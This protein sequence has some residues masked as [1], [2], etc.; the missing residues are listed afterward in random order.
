DSLVGMILP[1]DAEAPALP[2]DSEFQQV[3]S[4]VLRE[5]IVNLARIKEAVTQSVGGTLDAAGLDSWQDLM[6]GMK[7]GLLLLGKTR[8]VD[9]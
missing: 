2:E 9:V 3:Q 6:R 7:A 1:K 8:A 4:A 5:C